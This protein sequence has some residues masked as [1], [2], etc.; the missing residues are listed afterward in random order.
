MYNIKNMN[1][2]NE[3]QSVSFKTTTNENYTTSAI[4]MMTYIHEC[5]NENL[6]K[7][8]LDI[9]NGISINEAVNVYLNT[10]IVLMDKTLETIEKMISGFKKELS[11]I[12]KNNDTFTKKIDSIKD[13]VDEI[14]N[15][16]LTS[17]GFFYTEL[18]QPNILL[19]SEFKL[20]YSDLLDT[21]PATVY[22]KIMAYY[23]SGNY[24]N[25]IRKQTLNQSVDISDKILRDKI[26]GFYRNNITTKTVV[27][28]RQ[29]QI[30]DA[31]R[32]QLDFNVYVD[33][34]NELYQD[35][36]DQTNE[37]K[38]CISIL[39]K[40]SCTL[41]DINNLLYGETAKG[42]NTDNYV[43]HGFNDAITAITKK[44]I[45]FITE[46]MSICLLLVSDKISAMK[47]SIYQDTFI[48]DSFYNYLLEKDGE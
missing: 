45:S 31:I 28:Y 32:K 18:K 14:G 21:D 42:A 3:K 12:V 43:P 22:N 10:N 46:M 7:M 17:E 34:L 25:S 37:I 5:N 33:N 39:T 26:Y 30:A 11:N 29:P 47:E 41:G 44:K 40:E 1:L 36:K 20:G 2:K 23:N 4:S 15:A 9:V 6:S 48:L 35:I 8:A 19:A 24:M 27:V 16:T 38:R 13:R